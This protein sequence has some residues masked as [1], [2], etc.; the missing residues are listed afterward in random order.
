MTEPKKNTFEVAYEEAFSLACQQLREKDIAECGEKA[1]AQ[2][3]EQTG[4]SLKLKIRFLGRDITIEVPGFNFTSEDPPDIHIWE[5]ILIL[6]YLINSD[7]APPLDGSLINYRQVRDG[8]NY[9]STFEKRSTKPFLKN[10]GEAPELLSGAAEPLGAERISHGDFGIKVTALPYAPVF[11]VVWKGDAE[12][13]PDGSILFDAS[14]EQRL[15][16]EDIAVLCQ[17]M[18]FKIIGNKSR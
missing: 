2:V 12:F 18:V 6:H 11:F 5:K 3:L 14:I 15:S 16:A 1:G 9:F 7:Q 17:Q 13:P 8:S 10:F 4:E